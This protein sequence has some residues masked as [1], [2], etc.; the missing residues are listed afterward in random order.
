MTAFPQYDTPA[1]WTLVAAILELCLENARSAREIRQ[2]LNFQQKP[3]LLTMIRALANTGLLYRL[4]QYS[5]RAARYI[6]S[7][8]GR[9]SIGGYKA[10]TNRLNTQKAGRD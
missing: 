3:E 7:D 10:W 5:T 6:T 1:Y 8:V 2:A 9:R 4:P